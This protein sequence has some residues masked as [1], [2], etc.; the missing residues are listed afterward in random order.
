MTIEEIIFTEDE[1]KAR[2]AELG[3]QITE[4]YKDKSLLIVGILKGSVIFVSDLI[5]K[6]DL[7]LTLD[8]MAVSSYGNSTH[9][10][11]TVKIIK[12]LGEN[13]ENKDVLI[14]EDIVDS[15]LTLSYL[16]EMLS[17]RHPASIK[18]CALLDKPMNRKEEIS[19]DYVGFKG[20]GAFLVGY[21]LDYADHYRQLPYIGCLKL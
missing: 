11:G 13:I 12:D 8:F 19:I 16:K 10:S 5:R 7:P 14:V 9:S 17:A 6:I 3:L 21:G 20:P 15:G 1:I 18:I 4:D 2:V